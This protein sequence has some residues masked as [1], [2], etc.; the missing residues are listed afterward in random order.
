MNRNESVEEYMKRGGK[1][2]KLKESP[3]SV[4]YL[5]S[6]PCAV[7]WTVKAAPEPVRTVSWGDL[8]T[9]DKVKDDQYWKKLNKALDRELKKKR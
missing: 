5:F 9:D 2:T 6:S 7:G 3:E 4:G 1:I 8:H